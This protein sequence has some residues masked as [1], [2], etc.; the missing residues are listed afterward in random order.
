MKTGKWNKQDVEILRERYYFEG[1][2][3]A[4]Q[5]DLDREKKS[6]RGKARQMG[7]EYIGKK[8]W[9]EKQENEIRKRYP[10]HGA[11]KALQK[12]IG[13]SAYAID[14]KAKSMGVFRNLPREKKQKK[15]VVL[16]RWT[17]EQLKVLTEH[18]PSEGASKALRKELGLSYG[19]IR[20]KAELLGLESKYSRSCPQRTWTEQEIEV[21]AERYYCEGASASLVKALGHPAQS[22]RMKASKLGLV[23]GGYDCWSETD[24]KVLCDR[25]PFEGASKALQRTLN[26]SHS[27][28]AGKAF[29]IGLRCNR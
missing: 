20:Q 11:S 15:L 13:A 1:A 25:Y 10:R 12:D 27:A 18:Y 14:S 29:Q 9:T 6:I 8:L 23:Y 16:P 7:Y 28:I 19:M 17:D 2:S 24:E 3:D 5:K 26:R 22:I 21:L 4:L